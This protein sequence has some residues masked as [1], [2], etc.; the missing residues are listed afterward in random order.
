VGR[1]GSLDLSCVAR[2]LTNRDP[3]RH[4]SRA[5]HSAGA[6]P[7]LSPRAR[8]AIAAV[9]VLIVLFGLTT[10]CGVGPGHTLS[11][12]SLSEQIAGQLEAHYGIKQPAVTCPSGVSDHKGQTFVCAAT[13]DGQTVEMDG[14][15]TGSGRFTVVPRS[16]IISV[17]AIESSLATELQRQ[18]RVKPSVDC[19]PKQVLVVEV[20]GAFSCSAMFP[21]GKPR[22]IKVTVVNLQ[23][24]YRYQLAPAPAN[25]SPAAPAK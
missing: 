20:G 21:G 1:A 4:R 8:W 15:V 25:V 24:E 11:A 23:G 7:S 2:A 9:S 16:V 18:T 13:I 14:T 12:A 19:G 6:E 22:A 5:I 10:S 17:P 3:G